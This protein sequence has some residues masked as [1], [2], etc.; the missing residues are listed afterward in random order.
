MA[1]N[2]T[3]GATIAVEKNV[4]WNNGTT[5]LMDST[6]RSMKSVRGTLII[7]PEMKKN[8]FSLRSGL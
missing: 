6:N 1:K 3:N 7:T 8:I 4:A 5:T 2:T